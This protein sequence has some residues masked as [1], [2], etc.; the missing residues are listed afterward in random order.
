[1]TIYRLREV[2]S[3]PHFNDLIKSDQEDSVRK[4]NDS[5]GASNPPF[6]EIVSKLRI[7]HGGTENTEFH[8]EILC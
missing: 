3:Y 8:R 1:M 4:W 5:S 2:T 6:E 7:H